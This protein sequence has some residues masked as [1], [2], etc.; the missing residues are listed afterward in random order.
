MSELECNE[1]FP[2]KNK[3]NESNKE[4]IKA[5]SPRNISINRNGGRHRLPGLVIK[6]D[7]DTSQRCCPISS[8]CIKLGQCCTPGITHFY[9]Y[10]RIYDFTL[11]S[12]I[13]FYLTRHLQNFICQINQ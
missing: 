1:A 2:V 10:G 12:V 11:T 9:L 4:L 6:D 3:G 8:A 7:L 5:F 13:T